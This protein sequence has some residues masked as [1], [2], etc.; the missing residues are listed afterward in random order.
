MTMHSLTLISHPL[1]PFVQRAAIVLLEKQ[2]AFERIN[3]DL[4]AKPAWFL[5]LSPTAKVPLLQIRQPDGEEEILFESMAICEYLDETQPGPHLYPANPVARA[6]HRAWIEFGSATLGEAWG[7]LNAKNHASAE[8]KATSFKERLVQLE[9]VLGHGPY[10]DGETFGI[11]IV[12]MSRSNR[13]RSPC[14]ESAV[15][16]KHNSVRIRRLFRCQIAHRRSDFRR[17]AVAL[18]RNRI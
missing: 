10:F 8:A 13:T 16:R 17:R 12:V 1:C 7:Y 4:N 5:A 9:N 11:A 6:K 2:V 14:K 3:V 18:H 15:H